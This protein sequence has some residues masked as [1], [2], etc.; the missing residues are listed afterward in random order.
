VADITEYCNQFDS[1]GN[2]S[3]SELERFPTRDAL[4][5]EFFSD[6]L[7]ANRCAMIDIAPPRE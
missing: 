4:L 7:A 3:G 2:G 6:W 5:G 1:I